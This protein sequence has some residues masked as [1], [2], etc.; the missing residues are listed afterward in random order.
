MHL[1]RCLLRCCFCAALPRS[2]RIH[3]SAPGFQSTTG[4]H[5]AA[6][7]RSHQGRDKQEE[8]STG[9]ASKRAEL[10]SVF[11]CHGSLCTQRAAIN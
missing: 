10:C 2:A 1:R 6:V 4:T 7:A 8:E 11:G 3:S 9:T 5:A